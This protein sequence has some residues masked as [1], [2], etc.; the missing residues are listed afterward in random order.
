[1]YSFIE[2][3]YDNGD[4]GK[5]ALYNLFLMMYSDTA[6]LGDNEYWEDKKKALNGFM[7]R[8]GKKIKP[9][10]GSDLESVRT[11]EER[12]ANIIDMAENLKKEIDE[13]Q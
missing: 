12:K 6:V 9:D 13:K 11:D 10:D 5:Q 3:Q 1:M 8:C 4:K 2:Y 7:Q